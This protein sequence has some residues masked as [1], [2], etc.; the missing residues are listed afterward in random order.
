MYRDSSAA[1][2]R[3]P[4]AVVCRDP[5]A[6]VCR[7]PSAAVYRDPSAVVYRD[8]SEVTPVQCILRSQGTEVGLHGNNWITGGFTHQWIH[9]WTVLLEGGGNVRRWGL[10]GEVGELR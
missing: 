1:V 9:N 4:S 5:T 7:D 10:I 8:P 3:N 2:C 6:V